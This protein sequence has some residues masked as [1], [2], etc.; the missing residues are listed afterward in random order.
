MKVTGGLVG[1][2]LNQDARTKFFLIAGASKE[3]GKRVSQ[4]SSS[5]SSPCCSCLSTCRERRKAVNS[6]YQ[7]LHKSI[8][9]Y[10]YYQHRPLEPCHQSGDAR[11]G[12]ERFVWATQDRQ[13]AVGLLCE[14]QNPIRERKP[15][16]A[17][18]ESETS[19]IETVAKSWKWQRQTKSWN[20]KRPGLFSHEWWRCARA[21]QKSTSRKLL[22]ITNFRWFQDRCLL[23]MAQCFIVHPRVL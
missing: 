17:H 6:H 7:E 21:D 22:V 11:K 10:W 16:V 12:E 14:G 2:T 18:E 8:L 5:S 4:D 3:H 13:P 1:I 20:F 9:W 19:D 23:P 15:L